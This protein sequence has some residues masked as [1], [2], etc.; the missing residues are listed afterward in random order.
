MSSYPVSSVLRGSC[1]GSQPLLW[2]REHRSSHSV[3][4]PQ[5]HSHNGEARIGTH[6]DLFV[7]LSPLGEPARKELRPI[8]SQA[9]ESRSGF[10][11]SSQASKWLETPPAAQLACSPG[12]GLSQNH[13]LNCSCTSDPLKLHEISN[14]IVLTFYIWEIVC[15]TAI[16]NSFR[17]VDVVQSVN[18]VWLSCTPVD[19]EAFKMEQG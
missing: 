3:M 16:G 5:S 2:M 4:C 17:H 19:Y 6:Q 15:Y 9:S 10:P 18:C 1:C 14:L 8:K 12:D 11:S 13:Q 7:F